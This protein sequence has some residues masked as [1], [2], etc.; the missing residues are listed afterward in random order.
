MGYY[1]NRLLGS[2]FDPI[3]VNQN[4]DSYSRTRNSSPASLFSFK[5]IHES[6]YPDYFDHLITGSGGNIVWEKVNGKSVLT[7][8]SSSNGRA[9]RQSRR[10]FN[11]E[12]GKGIN[13]DITFN[14]SGASEFAEKRV[15]CYTDYDGLFMSVRNDGVVCANIITSTSSS[16]GSVSVPQSEW[17]VDKF[18]GTGPSGN[19]LDI[20][21][22]Q[23]MSID[24]AWMGVGIVNFNLWGGDR[25]YLVHRFLF[26]NSIDNVYMRTPSLP[27]RYEI[28]ATGGVP[29]SASMDAIS[30]AVMIEGGPD[31]VGYHHA[32]SSIVPRAISSNSLAPILSLRMKRDPENVM[33]TRKIAFPLNFHVGTTTNN[34]RG[35]AYLIKNPELSSP[36]WNSITGSSLE[37]DTSATMLTGGMTLL[38]D[39]AGITGDSTAP[40]FIVRTNVFTTDITGTSDIYTLAV[41][42]I[43]SDSWLGAINWYELL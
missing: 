10:W 31:F 27:I 34:S 13:Y 35:I 17:N 40:E 23:N 32:Q 39:I 24:F 16:F 42:S 4:T 43:G 2:R 33:Y 36:S 3:H 14:F 7:C 5:Q 15:G 18:D 20:T 25:H 28:V 1:E 19:T 21:K 11:Y 9:L 41:Y 6:G 37:Y 29:T 8:G 26:A 30:C 22:T 12:P 38:A